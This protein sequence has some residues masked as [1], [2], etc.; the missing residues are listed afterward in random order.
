MSTDI[1]KFRYSLIKRKCVYNYHLLKLL[2]IFKPPLKHFFY[3]P[4]TPL[5]CFHNQQQ[6][7]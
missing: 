3:K 5:D 2:F 6:L 4:C 1:F 7:G